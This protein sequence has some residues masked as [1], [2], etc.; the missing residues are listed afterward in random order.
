MDHLVLWIQRVGHDRVTFT[1]LSFRNLHSTVSMDPSWWFPNYTSLYLIGSP[2]FP[3]S[4]QRTM[5]GTTASHNLEFSVC[6]P[7]TWA[8]TVS[9]LTQIHSPPSS[10]FIET[11]ICFLRWQTV[12]LK[13]IKN[14]QEQ[15][16]TT[17]APPS[18]SISQI[19]LPHGT[20]LATKMSVVVIES[21]K[22]P[23]MFPEKL[24]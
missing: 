7:A 13:K 15:Q 23:K 8:V 17:S 10:L 24:C 6:L 9:C 20:D 14:K 5:A 18:P 1:S 22:R 2:R 16:K 12:K 19:P 11:P 3:R 4:W 21:W